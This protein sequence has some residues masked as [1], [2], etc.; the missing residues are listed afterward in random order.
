[1]D[2]R[3]QLHP[4]PLTDLYLYLTGDCNLR[5]SHCWISPSYSRSD[6][7]A[8]DRCVGLDD[9]ERVIGDAVELGLQRVKLTGG[10]PLLYP[11]LEGL[12]D[13]LVARGLRAGMESNGVLLDERSVAL[14]ARSSVAN[15][16]VSLDA[17]EPGLHDALRGVQGSF[18]KCLK[19]L[20]L[21]GRAQLS[22][23]IIMTLQRRNLEQIPALVALCEGLGAH[24]L[25]I[26]PLQPCGRARAAFARGDNLEVPELLELYGQLETMRPRA[27]GLRVCLD[28]PLAML[29]LAE[30]LEHGSGQCHIVNILGVLASGDYSICGVGQQIEALR[31][32]DLRETPIKEVWKSH[33]LL[34]ELRRSLP[35]RLGGICGHCI[36]K[37]QCLGSCR[38]NAYVMSRDLYAPYFLC[39]QYHEAG[40]FPSSR[41]Y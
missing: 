8:A 28:L 18:D 17:A 31:L 27:S 3:Q 6:A 39:Q 33:P 24:T 36:F 30:I 22:F 35:D 41:Y 11:E 32:G 34:H 10:E 38:A 23:E 37:F 16:S 1:M 14:L 2:N 15:L 26:N 29:S 5:C 12:L 20:K 9:L 40:L 21:L 25:K 19:G 4:P 13:F 7:A